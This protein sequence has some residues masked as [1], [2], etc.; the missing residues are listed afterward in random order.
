MKK[1]M[2]KLQE[3]MKKEIESLPDCPERALPCIDCISFPMCLS[4]YNERIYMGRMYV[5]VVHLG[6]I[7]EP[8]TEYIYGYINNKISKETHRATYRILEADNYFITRGSQ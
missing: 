5:F 2:K 1:S 8:L 4:R 3:I 7:C 6:N